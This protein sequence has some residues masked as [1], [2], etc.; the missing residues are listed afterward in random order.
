MEIIL[1]IEG[2]VLSLVSIIGFF[3]AH[4]KKWKTKVAF[5]FG[6]TLLMTFVT[7]LLMLI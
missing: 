4:K 2:I 5:T 1:L 3:V 7:W 6:G